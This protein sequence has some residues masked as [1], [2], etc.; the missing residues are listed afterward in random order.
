MSIPN[1]V[2]EAREPLEQPEQAKQ[3]S[4]TSKVKDVK[5]QKA[6]RKG[7][8]IRRQKLEA[9]KAKLA[10]AKV[11]SQL[12]NNKQHAV[13]SKT[14]VSSEPGPRLGLSIVLALMAGVV[15]FA[16]AKQQPSE[17]LEKQVHYSCAK[18]S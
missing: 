2:L 15:L 12:A 13:S 17:R 8:A 11:T 4:P 6:G 14:H 16:V 3:P 10:A 5:K 7:A 1:D 9:L 18:L